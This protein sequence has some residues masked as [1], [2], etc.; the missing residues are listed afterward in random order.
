MNL[1]TPKPHIWEQFIFMPKQ[2]PSS[3][4]FYRVV[5]LP[6]RQIH[7]IPQ[8]NHKMK[9]LQ[10]LLCRSCGLCQITYPTIM[11]PTYLGVLQKIAYVDALNELNRNQAEL[12]YN[13]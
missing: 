11:M 5:A 12:P 8:V 9:S 6:H 13:H 4:P 3:C 10:L 1:S 2:Q 7:R